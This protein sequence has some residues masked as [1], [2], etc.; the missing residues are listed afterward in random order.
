MITVKGKGQKE[1]QGE[2][3]QEAFAS[4]FPHIELQEITDKMQAQV[5]IELLNGKRKSRT[6]YYIKKVNQV[7]THST[8]SKEAVAIG[9]EVG[10]SY[11]RYLTKDFGTITNDVFTVGHKLTRAEIKENAPFAGFS[12]VLHKD[13]NAIGSPETPLC[14]LFKTDEENVYI[15]ILLGRQG[16]LSDTARVMG[17]VGY[18]YRFGTL[19]FKKTENIDVIAKA[20]ATRF[21]ELL[22]IIYDIADNTQSLY[23]LLAFNAP[24]ETIT[25][26]EH[27]TD[28]IALLHLAISRWTTVRGEKTIA[29]VDK[30]QVKDAENIKVLYANNVSGCG[31]NCHLYVEYTQG[32]FSIKVIYGNDLNH[33]LCSET[34]EMHGPINQ[35]SKVIARIM[36]SCLIAANVNRI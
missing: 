5:C 4:L 6:F 2:G 18:I 16:Y 36:G 13:I 8:L 14:A 11:Y 27:I 24:L 32:H 25:T 23:S 19:T 10:H 34:G 30:I 33:V 3:P 9:Y 20:L 31:S 15:D 17:L 7:K 35:N 12:Y 22:P 28:D 29:R 26:I 1:A 21:N